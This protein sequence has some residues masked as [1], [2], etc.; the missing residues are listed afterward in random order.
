[1]AAGRHQTPAIVS[2]V[3]AA[4]AERG[5]EVEACG[6]DQAEPATEAVRG[7]VRRGVDAVFAMG[8]D[9][10][11]RDAASG[12]Y[13]SRVPLGVLPAGTT[14]VVAR[15]LGVPLEA[16]PAA[17]A[18]ATGRTARMD[19]GFCGERPFLMQATAGFDASVIARIDRR[20]KARLGRVGIALQGLL[21]WWCY[22][23]PE[24]ELRVDGRP[25]TA[26]QLA[27]CNIP[28][29][30]GSFRLVRSGRFDDRRLDVVLF[31]GKGR[32]A[33]LSFF[34]DL[35]RGAHE[36]R[37]DVEVRTADAVELVGPP[38]AD[39]Q[40]DGDPVPGA[41]PLSMRLAPEP[42]QVLVPA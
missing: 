25:A 11:V 9:G 32:R 3:S 33:T 34:V 40:I 7:A 28:E 24:L 5:F 15:A 27:V 16:L 8:G 38:G 10:T 29:Y 14:N 36:G 35:V 42:I 20:L 41:V 30:G 17:R 26:R 22:A 6:V 23:Y 21:Q 18:L 12:V 31:H 19:V 2:G 39:V 37:S 4:L 13:G 1:M